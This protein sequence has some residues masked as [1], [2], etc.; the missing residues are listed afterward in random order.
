M[1]GSET[2]V[3]TKKDEQQLGIWERKPKTALEGKPGGKKRGD[4]HF[5]MAGSSWV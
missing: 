1:Y 5:E 3:F 2:L 4:D